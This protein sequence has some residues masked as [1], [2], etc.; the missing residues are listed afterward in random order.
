MAATLIPAIVDFMQ[1]SCSE[2]TAA[3]RAELRRLLDKVRHS[4]DRLKR[5]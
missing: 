2:L 5:P 1:D 4:V 3:E